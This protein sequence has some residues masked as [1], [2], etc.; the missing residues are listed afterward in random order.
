VIIAVLDGMAYPELRLFK[1]TQIF[2]NT[3][4]T[5]NLRFKAQ[6]RQTIWKAIGGILSP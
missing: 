4:A 3:L 1:V 6:S 5:L 2:L